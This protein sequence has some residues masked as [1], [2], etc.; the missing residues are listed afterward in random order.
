MNSRWLPSLALAMPTGVSR[1]PVTRCNS[2]RM[3][4]GSTADRSGVA[5]GVAVG[6]G[7]GVV[8]GGMGLGVVLGGAGAGVSLAPVGAGVALGGTG[9]GVALGGAKLGVALGRTAVGIGLVLWPGSGLALGCA[10]ATATGSYSALSWLSSP[11]PARP[12]TNNHV[13][14]R[15]FSSLDSIMPPL[16]NSIRHPVK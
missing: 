6:T 3:V 14:T 12:R 1:P 11:Q 9:V 4:P 10:E 2:T 13:T 16:Y 5:V 8:V 15:A 7:V